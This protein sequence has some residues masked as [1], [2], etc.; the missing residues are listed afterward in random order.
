M[1]DSQWY[2]LNGFVTIKILDTAKC[3]QMENIYICKFIFQKLNIS[4]NLFT[5]CILVVILF[6]V[7]ELLFLF[8]PQNKVLF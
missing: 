1:G 8:F 5:W 2:I 3:L 6:E 7:K 4:H